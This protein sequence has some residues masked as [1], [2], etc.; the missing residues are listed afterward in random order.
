MEKLIKSPLPKVLRIRPEIQKA[1]WNKQ[2]PQSFK[3]GE[4]VLVK[5][6]QNLFELREGKIIIMH[7][8][9]RKSRKTYLKFFETLEG[10]RIK[11][12]FKNKNK[13][14]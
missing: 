4:I 5:E 13:Q 14:S 11:L 2:S 12:N 3:V 8:A 9:S 1:N 7:F 6:Q 10:K